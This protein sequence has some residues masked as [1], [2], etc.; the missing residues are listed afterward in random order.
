ML[1]LELTSHIL[2]VERNLQKYIVP[3]NGELKWQGGD[4]QPGT[5]ADL[6]ER[7]VTRH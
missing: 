2:I 3:T 7:D 5:L 1:Q 4:F 6:T